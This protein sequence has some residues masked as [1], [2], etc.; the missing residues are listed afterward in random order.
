MAS[1]KLNIIANFTGQ[2][3]VALINFGLVPLYIKF[4]GIESYGL[5]GFFVSLQTLVS[6]LD[7]GL[8]TTAN[9]EVARHSGSANGTD[10]Q[11]LFDILSSLQYVYF[12]FAVIIVVGFWGASKSLATAWITA[13]TIS[14]NVLQMA[15][16]IFGI[17]V[18]LRWP[19]A[20]YNGILR[21]AEKQVKLNMITI[22]IASVK[23]IGS[24]ILIIFFSRSLLTLLA[25]HL[26]CGFIE[27]LVTGSFAWKSVPKPLQNKRNFSYAALRSVFGFSATVAIISILAVA[28]KQIDKVIISKLLPL[29]DVGYYNTAL[30]VYAG[31]QLFI[32]P[33]STALFPRLSSL[34][35][36]GKNKCLSD[37]YHRASKTISFSTSLVAS[38]IMF[39][40]RDLLYLWTQSPVVAERAWMP[41][42]V[43]ACAAIFNSVMQASYVLQLASGLQR[44]P[45]INNIIAFVVFTPISYFLVL[46]LGIVGG[47]I[48]WA[49]YNLIYFSIT[50]FFT[51]KYLLKEEIMDWYTKD[52]LP[53]IGLSLIVFGCIFLLSQGHSLLSKFLLVVAGIIVYVIVSFMMDRSLKKQFKDLLC[54]PTQKQRG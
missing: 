40:S 49:A 13:E 7:L 30:Q 26:L 45:L 21:G 3:W 15:I 42:S 31:I 51:H 47:A 41:L 12:G 8:G 48:S 5:L 44:I 50:P 2:V 28:I 46:K 11:L 10:G 34:I 37:V 1:I 18:G 16:I 33:I 14:S 54:M 17:T 36:I 20:L 19:L 35:S 39:N 23:G 24:A 27:V 53:F 43:L 9:R 32:T 22:A 29:T 6:V 38:I 4:L 25:W 52:T